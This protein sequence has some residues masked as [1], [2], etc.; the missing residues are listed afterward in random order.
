MTKLKLL[1]LIPIIT[2][3][4]CCQWCEE[5]QSDIEIINTLCDLITGNGEEQPTLPE[6]II[7]CGGAEELTATYLD[8]QIPSYQVPGNNPVNWWKFKKDTSVP[9]SGSLNW[10]T[11]DTTDLTNEIIY[12]TPDFDGKITG[13]ESFITNIIQMGV[14]SFHYVHPQIVIEVGGTTGPN[15]PSNGASSTIS[16]ECE[17]WANIG[18]QIY[19]TYEN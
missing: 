9:G 8:S 17:G 14:D 4:S 6:Q 12:T 13:Y 1:I 10:Y 2:L 15:A 11:T 3:S 5:N 18:D 16:I 7:D 19:L